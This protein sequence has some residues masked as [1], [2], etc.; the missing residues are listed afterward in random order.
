LQNLYARIRADFESNTFKVKIIPRI[1]P[2][3]ARPR[4]NEDAYRLL[5]K[6]G[7]RLVVW[8]DADYTHESQAKKVVVKPIR[9]SYAVP[10]K[11]APDIAKDLTRLLRSKNWEVIEG[12][13]SSRI[14]FSG[15]IGEVSY[16]LIGLMFL[17][18]ERFDQASDLLKEIFLTLRSAENITDAQRDILATSE[19]LL[20]KIIERRWLRL[21]LWPGSETIKNDLPKATKLIDE[22]KL[23]GFSFG[24]EMLEAQMCIHRNDIVG[25]KRHLAD[26]S[27]L[28]AGSAPFLLSSAFMSFYEKGI[29]RGVDLLN[30]GLKS[31]LMNDQLM[32]LARWYEQT[33]KVQPEKVFLN[34]P[35]GLIYFHAGNYMPAKECFE[36]SIDFNRNNPFFTKR[37]AYM[38]DK[39]MESI[40]RKLVQDRRILK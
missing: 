24:V 14:S 9:F 5:E 39:K 19:V 2:E 28:G 18:Q 23:L 38:I 15:D 34:I 32:L 33:M 36:A 31:E 16:Y 35:L 7:A 8:G 21:E 22:Q 37:I 20:C 6:T 30:R 4:K 29:Q 17:F 11:F 25:A 13:A 26:A 3:Y 12:S 40:E 10:S 1:V 27:K